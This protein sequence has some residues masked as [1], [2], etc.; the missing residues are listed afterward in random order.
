M[1][2]WARVVVSWS[3]VDRAISGE[4]DIKSRIARMAQDAQ[5]VYAG[6]SSVGGSD[7]CWTA[8][9]I[10]SANH[11]VAEDL[12]LCLE[13]MEWEFP[14]EVEFT[15]RCENM[16]RSETWRLGD[17]CGGSRYEGQAVDSL[18]GFYPQEPPGENTERYLQRIAQLER[19]L[20]ALH[21]KMEWDLPG[22]VWYVRD[23]GLLEG[24]E[25]LSEKPYVD[26]LLELRLDFPIG[27]AHHLRTVYV[28]KKEK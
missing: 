23:R 24:W 12:Q 18:C 26:R 14:D 19:S 9:V 1:S 13:S 20:Q 3:D 4:G 15:F 25:V 10:F 11:F 6:D 2:N 17:P 5:M 27:N 7:R 8:T 28:L 22:G 21:N 16:D